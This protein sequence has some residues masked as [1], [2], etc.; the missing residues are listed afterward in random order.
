MSYEGFPLA[1]LFLPPTPPLSQ[2]ATPYLGH[3]ETKHSFLEYHDITETTPQRNR[4]E[5]AKILQRY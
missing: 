4:K 5:T 3:F 1:W 2:F